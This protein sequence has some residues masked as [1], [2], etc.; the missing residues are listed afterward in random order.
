MSPWVLLL[1]SFCVLF[2]VSSSDHRHHFVS[3]PLCSSSHRLLGL[4]LLQ[5]LFIPVILSPQTFWCLA[6]CIYFCF[7]I[8]SLL[9][10][11]G[12]QGRSTSRVRT[13]YN[14]IGRRRA[15]VEGKESGVRQRVER[16]KEL[17]AFSVYM[18]RTQK[19]WAGTW[20]GAILTGTGPGLPGPN[21]GLW[22]RHHRR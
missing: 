15:G 5:S 10:K 17:Q 22:R 11:E 18:D 21:R 3:H 8:P 20:V 1:L 4:T 13:C 7:N 2:C 19:A 9:S 12:G 6:N 14:G 16:G